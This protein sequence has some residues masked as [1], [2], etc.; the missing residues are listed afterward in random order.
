MG[1]IGKEV[2]MNIRCGHTEFKEG[3]LAR[4]ERR[5]ETWE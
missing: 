5:E 4:S 2:I 1:L 3:I